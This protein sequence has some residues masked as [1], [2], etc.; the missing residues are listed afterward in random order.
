MCMCVHIYAYICVYVHLY[1]LEHVASVKR[2]VIVYLVPWLVKGFKVHQ[3]ARTNI[4]ANV[5]VVKHI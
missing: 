2:V 4:L 5:Q 3:E 1:A